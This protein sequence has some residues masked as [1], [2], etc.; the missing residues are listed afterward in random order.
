MSIYKES[1]W[2]EVFLYLDLEILST[3]PKNRVLIKISDCI[4]IH[5]FPLYYAICG[6][7]KLC[8]W[9][10]LSFIRLLEFP[11]P[12]SKYYRATNVRYTATRKLSLYF[13]NIFSFFLGYYI[14]ISLKYTGNV[15]KDET[16]RFLN[17]ANFQRVQ[18]FD[19]LYFITLKLVNEWL[20]Q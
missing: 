1:I 18:V 2:G 3:S 5:L 13:A 14:H 12:V 15:T 20:R 11:L 17:R 4:F 6:L 7:Y 19:T 16:V 9:Y 10:G 8:K